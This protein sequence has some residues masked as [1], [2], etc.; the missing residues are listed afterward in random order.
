MARTRKTVA[1]LTA[2]LNLGRRGMPAAKSIIGLGVL[3]GAATAGPT[4]KVIKTTE[5]DAYE[6]AAQ[7]GPVTAALAAGSGD[8]F[9]GT[10]RKAAKLSISTAKKESF[11]NLKALIDTL[12]SH[13]AMKQHKPAIKTTSTSRRVHEEDRNV[14]LKAFIYAASKENDNDYHLIV[15]QSPTA[16]TEVYMTMELSGLPPKSSKSYAKLKKARNAFQTFFSTNLPGTTYDFYDPPVPIEVAGSLFWDASHA[17]G[18][19]PGPQSLKKKMP[20]VWEVHPI[21][22]IKLNP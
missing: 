14:A 19:R 12:P 20:T 11:A 17:K 15:G 4:F 2:G 21:S 6:K 8:T 7:A 18:Q 16:A 10:A 1:A 9:A 3:G 22:S 13:Q 5:I